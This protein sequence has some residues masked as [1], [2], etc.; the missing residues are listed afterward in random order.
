MK[1]IRKCDLM[2]AYA[3]GSV[4][5]NS[6]AFRCVAF[7]KLAERYADEE[8]ENLTTKIGGLLDAYHLGSQHRLQFRSLTRK[9]GK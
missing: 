8:S 9:W 4:N 3:L 1:T 7:M 2:R 6:P 5:T